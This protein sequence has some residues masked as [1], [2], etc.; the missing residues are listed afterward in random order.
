MGYPKFPYQPALP[1]TDFKDFTRPKNLPFSPPS[2]QLSCRVAPLS[3]PSK[4]ERERQRERRGIKEREATKEKQG[5]PCP[6]HSHDFAM[7]RDPTLSGS[8]FHPPP[9]LELDREKNSGPVLNHRLS[10]WLRT[11]Y[12]RPTS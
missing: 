12:R 8:T 6:K 3:S 1:R 9:L 5:D 7:A 10:G 11:H 4:T 2:L